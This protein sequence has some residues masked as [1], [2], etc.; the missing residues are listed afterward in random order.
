VLGNIDNR[1]VGWRLTSSLLRWAL[2][3]QVVCSA[4]PSAAASAQPTNAVILELEGQAEVA[5][6]GS[7]AWR[8]AQA[9][10]VLFPGDQFRIG[11]RSRAVVRL[12]DLSHLRL[13]H[14]A[15]IQIPQAS[16]RRSGIRLLRGLL[17]FFHRD[18]R[19]EFPVHTPSLSAGIL[20]TE[21]A[22]SVTAQGATRLQLIDGELEMSNAFGRLS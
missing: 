14:G 10:Q 17:Y 9:G 5:R 8:V 11:E 12:S 1:S 3:S 15:Y 21:F 4:L 7:T 6:A 18:R 20:G 22:I 13:G 2:L 19:G 16:P